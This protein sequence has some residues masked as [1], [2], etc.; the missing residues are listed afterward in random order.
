MAA[1]EDANLRAVEQAQVAAEAKAA[2]DAAT[3]SNQ[4]LKAAQARQQA[5]IDA[6]Q[7]QFAADL[8]AATKATEA[9]QAEHRAQV[10]QLLHDGERETLRA[11]VAARAEMQQLLERADSHA[12]ELLVSCWLVLVGALRDCAFAQPLDARTHTHT[13]AQ[14]FVVGSDLLPFLLPPQPFPIHLP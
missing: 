8:A 2:F 6:L 14:T 5:Q 7:V 11:T 3:A 10:Q 4:D 9:L 1:A 13:R 12:A